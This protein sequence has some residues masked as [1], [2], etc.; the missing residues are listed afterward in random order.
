MATDLLFAIWVFLPAGIA[1][2][3]PIFAAH[4]PILKRWEAPLDF[5]LS[6]QGKRLLGPN[7]TIRGLLS[8]LVAGGLFALLQSTVQQS[9]ANEIGI[10]NSVL[11]TFVFGA[12]LGFGALMGDAIES[13]FKRQ[14]NIS[15]GKSWFPFDQTD[16]IIGGCIPLLAWSQLN[17]SQYVMIFAVYFGLHLLVSYIGYVLKLKKSPL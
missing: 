5:G 10:T 8:G 3:T 14:K 4:L 11:M 2:M 17:F 15:S 7:K 12:S 6:C 9:Y 16:Y 13:F 1:N